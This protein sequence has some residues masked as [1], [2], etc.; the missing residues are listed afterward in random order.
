VVVVEVDDRSTVVA[1][2]VAL[3]DRLGA[4][5]GLECLVLDHASAGLHS[6]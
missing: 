4:L 1:G 6:P 2:G 3:A 5:P